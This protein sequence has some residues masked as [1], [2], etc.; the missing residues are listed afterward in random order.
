M[1][2]GSKNEKENGFVE[3][4]NMLIWMPKEEGGKL[5]VNL[6]RNVSV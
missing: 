4:G 5:M 6:K 1:K 3:E 2:A